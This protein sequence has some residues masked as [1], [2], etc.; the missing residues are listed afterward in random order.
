[1]ECADTGER[2]TQRERERER[3]SERER[4]GAA[5][6]GREERVGGGRRREEAHLEVHCHLHWCK[7]EEER[8][9]A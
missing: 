7:K 5:I 4:Q 8:S 2:E 9:E 6:T 3:A 1:M